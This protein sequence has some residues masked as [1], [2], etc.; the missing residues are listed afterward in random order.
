MTS[1]EE[2]WSGSAFRKPH[3]SPGFAFWLSFMRWQRELNARLRPLGITQPQFAIL[4]V[5]GWLTRSGQ[6]ITQK[7]IVDFLRLDRMHVSEIVSRL[8]QDGMLQRQRSR[9][10]AR[11]KQVL[12]TPAGRSL[13]AQAVPLVESFDQA[14]FASGD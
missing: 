2:A 8:E 5:C 6:E 10:D 3:E 13:L 4:A 7:Q 1:K 11:A 12:L 9:Q 14:F